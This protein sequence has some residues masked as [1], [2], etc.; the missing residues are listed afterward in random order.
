M[1]R[2]NLNW[3]RSF[4]L[5]KLVDARRHATRSV[6]MLHPTFNISL[7]GRVASTLVDALYLNGP[8]H[9]TLYSRVDVRRSII[10]FHQ[11]LHDD[12]GLPLFHLQTF[13]GSINS[14]AASGWKRPNRGKVFIILSFIELKHPN[15]ATLFRLR[16]RI[17]PVNL[18]RIVQGTCPLAFGA[19][20]L[21][22]FHFFSF[23]GR[24]PTPL[25][26]SNWNLAGSIATC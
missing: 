24:K 11:I 18:L 6:W 23:G 15:L 9:H 20:I 17:N 19:I 21:V 5:C 2:P 13:L 25:S 3:H 7:I 14:L 1:Y 10:D 22:K 12:R 8:L 16:T 26:R 4:D